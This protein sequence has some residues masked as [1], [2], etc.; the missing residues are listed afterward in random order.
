MTPLDCITMGRIPTCGDLEYFTLFDT[1]FNSS[2]R[3]PWH[4]KI[5][6]IIGV[7]KT[8]NMVITYS[9][10]VNRLIK[11]VGCNQMEDV[12]IT[13]IYIFRQV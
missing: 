6:I 5:T 3:N 11:Q 1:Q 9:L 2:I 8:N 7:R 12:T 13:D 10:F 4:I